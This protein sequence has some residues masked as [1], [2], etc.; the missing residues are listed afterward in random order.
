MALRRFLSAR[1]P[2]WSSLFDI[3]DEDDRTEV[4]EAL[5]RLMEGR[6]LGGVEPTTLNYHGTDSDGYMLS[7]CDGRLIVPFQLT[8]LPDGRESVR[9]FTP[10]YLSPE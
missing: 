10:I 4:F 5:F 7:L 8:P 3:Q 9:I 2:V 1:E 6:R